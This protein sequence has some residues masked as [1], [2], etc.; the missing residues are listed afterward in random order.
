M[1]KQT[2]K[3]KLWSDI[4]AGLSGLLA[5]FTAGGAYAALVPL[6]VAPWLAIGVAVLGYIAKQL[7]SR[8][9]ARPKRRD[10]TPPLG[11]S[12]F[13]AFALALLLGSAACG[14]TTWQEAVIRTA[15]MTREATAE[16]IPSLMTPALEKQRAACL[17]LA[18]EPR[19]ACLLRIKGHLEAWHVARAA[20]NTTIAALDALY[21]SFSGLPKKQPAPTPVLPAMAPAPR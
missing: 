3:I 14:P 11:P 5:L 16:T 4:L 9:P 17:K 15:D 1:T 7:E 12:A 18:G 21:R 13:A 20:L 2:D 19:K 6:K 10:G 8:I